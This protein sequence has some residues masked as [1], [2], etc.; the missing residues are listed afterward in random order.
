MQAR[1]EAEVELVLDNED[2]LL[3]VPASEI[4]I[5][6]RL[7]RAGEGEYRVN[8]ARCRLVDVLELLSDTGLGKEAH[9]V[10]SQGRVESIVTSKPVSYTHLDVYKRQDLGP[11]L[12]RELPAQ[13]TPGARVVSESDRRAPLEL[14]LPTI[15]ERRYGDTLIRIHQFATT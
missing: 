2:G 1:G 12:A 10:I 7:N 6:R 15:R 14:G 3:G 13:L 8:G 5:S 4:S 9:S 11:L